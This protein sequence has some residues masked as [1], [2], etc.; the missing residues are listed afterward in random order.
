MN[1]IIGFK[2]KNY[3]YFVNLKDLNNYLTKNFNINV[4]ERLTYLTIKDGM[5]FA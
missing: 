5:E 2:K 4:I 1:K 3:I